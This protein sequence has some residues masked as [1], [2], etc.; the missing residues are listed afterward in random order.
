MSTHYLPHGYGES[1]ACGADAIGRRSPQHM[2]PLETDCPECK[3]TRYWVADMLEPQAGRYS[4]LRAEWVHRQTLDGTSPEHR[5]GD[6]MLWKVHL[7]DEPEP[8][9]GHFLV[10]ERP[11]GFVIALGF[12][13]T[14]E[15]GRS[16][17]RYWDDLVAGRE[18]CLE[19]SMNGTCIHSDHTA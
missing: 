1:F 13:S 5:I 11:E 6:D 4:T 14:E 16:L 2:D 8:V 17:D 9:R 3:A 18:V 7:P 19:K 12:G 15:A 10:L